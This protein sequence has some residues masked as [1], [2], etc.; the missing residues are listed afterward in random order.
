[1]KHLKGSS[2]QRFHCL[3]FCFPHQKG[4]K[5][6]GVVMWVK[7]LGAQ[8]AA[9]P[10]F[11]AIPVRATIVVLRSVFQKSKKTQGAATKI[12]SFHGYSPECCQGEQTDLPTITASHNISTTSDSLS[13]DS[14]VSQGAVVEE[15]SAIFLG[16][17][18]R[19][20]H[21]ISKYILESESWGERGLMGCD[22]WWRLASPFHIP[23]PGVWKK[24][25]LRNT[26]CLEKE[27]EQRS[28]QPIVMVPLFHG[29]ERAMTEIKW[30][31][32]M[33]LGDMMMRTCGENLLSATFPCLHSHSGKE[34]SK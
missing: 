12:L 2:S 26:W 30:M 4:G 9:V 23:T 34:V 24:V 6:W 25:R 21:H 33:A 27:K 13:Q 11:H 16:S 8:K 29:D 1:M 3:G 32:M 17:P 20:C 14:T 10:Q 18:S 31:T 28:Q 5:H 15:N 7:M 19:E 22:R